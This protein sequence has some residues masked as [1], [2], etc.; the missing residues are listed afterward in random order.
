M[1][2]MTVR[3]RCS[4]A[5]NTSSRCLINVSKSMSLVIDGPVDVCLESSKARLTGVFWARAS[6]RRAFR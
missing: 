4:A 5:Q 3:Q 2:V 6:T 1:G